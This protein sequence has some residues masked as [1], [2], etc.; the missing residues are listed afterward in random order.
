MIWGPNPNGSF[1]IKS[2]YNIQIQDRPF[3]PHAD[4]LKKMWKLDIPPKVKI[5]AWM[6]IWNR[7]Q[8]KVKFD[9]S[10]MNSQASTGFVIRDCDGHV[11]LADSNN[12]CEKSINVAESVALR[13]GLVAA[14]E[15][16]WD[17]IVIED[18]SKLIIDSI[19][20][21]ASP[22]WSIQL[23]IQDIWSLSS[24][25]N[26]VRFQHVFREANFT[27]DAVAK[28]E[29]GLSNQVD[30]W[31]REAVVG[32]T[33]VEAMALAS[34]WVSQKKAKRERKGQWSVRFLG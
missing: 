17:Q 31:W 2:A 23:I 20:K 13:D 12:I 16:L 4:M 34:E 25:V 22:P 3:Y 15:R 8:I 18:D 19:L 30:G 5:F 6:L 21:K 14:I 1:T 11:L 27:A 24:S 28:L 32:L 9:G 7:L 26:S 29:H 33:V 10:F